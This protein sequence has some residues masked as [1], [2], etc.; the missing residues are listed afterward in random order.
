MELQRAMK[1]LAIDE[2]FIKAP[3][4]NHPKMKYQGISSWPPTWSGA[5]GVEDTFPGSEDGVLEDVEVVER[6][7]IGPRRLEVLMSYRGRKSPGQIWVDDQKA[8]PVLYEALRKLVGHPM[9][10]IGDL[11]I[12]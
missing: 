11:Q 1:E 9:R 8:I 7:F 2:G 12:D 6:D 5:Y 10:E 4:R 3:L